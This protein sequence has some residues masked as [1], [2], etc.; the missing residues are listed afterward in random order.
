MI[1]FD[2]FSEFDS[3]LFGRV[4][5]LFLVDLVVV[6]DVI[7]VGLNDSHVSR[8]QKHLA[9]KLLTLFLPIPFLLFVCCIFLG[10][11]FF[12]LLLLFFLFLNGNLLPQFLVPFQ[13]GF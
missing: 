10:L 7:L 4:G 6:L 11:L 5:L 8:R 12:L 1:V 9:N 3:L 13:S 2:E